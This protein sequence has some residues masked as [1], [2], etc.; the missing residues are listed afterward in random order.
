[1]AHGIPLKS[2]WEYIADL[3]DSRMLL[4]DLCLILVQPLR[5]FMAACSDEL[6]EMRG[7]RFHYR[8]WAATKPDA[9]D[10]VLLHG[11]TGHAHSWDTFAQG[12]TDR[13]RV[14]ALDQRGH[15]QTQWAPR[16]AYGVEQMADDLSAFVGA[17]S[18]K[19]FALLGLSMGG[20]VAIRYAAQSP[21][22]LSRLV[23]VDIGPEIDPVGMARIQTSVSGADLFASKQAALAVSRANNPISSDAEL[24][25]RVM[26]GLMLTESGQWTYRYDR[27]LRDPSTARVRPDPD[28]A[29]QAVSK[30]KVPTLIVRGSESD[31]LALP[32][33]QRMIRDIPQAS[34]VQV[35]KA[36][37]SVP[38]DQ[39]QGF[40]DAVR[41][42]L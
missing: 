8:D 14:L 30:I 29:W 3:T 18:L 21:P 40:L 23:I 42:F 13:Y 6:I 10:L 27:A 19:K 31:I 28:K 16:D 24:Q 20:N 22:E 7:L 11:Y 17:L 12:M 32:V 37:H 41:S 35:A 2:C 39:P 33:A 36:G 4:Y 15:G 38:L 34:L 5:C 25:L 9:P 1:M 26:H